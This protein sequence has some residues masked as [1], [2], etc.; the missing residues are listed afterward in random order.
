MLVTVLAV[1]V[2]NIFYFKHTRWAPTFKRCHQYL[3]FVDNIKSTRSTYN[4]HLCSLINQYWNHNWKLSYKLQIALSF[5]G[6]NDLFKHVCFIHFIFFLAMSSL[7]IHLNT[8]VFLLDQLKQL[9]FLL[10]IFPCI[11]NS[12]FLRTFLIDFDSRT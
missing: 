4:Q 2:T 3:N 8:Q 12:S 7:R 5:H 10:R 9:V 11:K 1:F 6:I